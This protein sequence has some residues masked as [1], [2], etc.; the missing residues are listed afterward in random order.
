[1]R[2]G[3]ER[4]FYSTSLDFIQLPNAESF[5]SPQD[6]G[7]TVLHELGHWTSNVDRLDRDI[8]N[9]FGSEKY[10]QEELRAELASV[11]IG[12]T[13]GLPCDVPNHA[14]YIAS[15]I[16]T[17][18]EDKREIFRAASDAQKIADY[19]LTFHPDYAHATQR[20]DPTDDGD[21]AGHGPQLVQ[22]AA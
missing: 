19:L 10:A 13:L 7:I 12:A 9:R 1:M 18:R 3:G 5:H 15:W 22:E 21:G 20:V 8:K 2:I 17:L 16:K 6:W 14:S 4:A 11:F